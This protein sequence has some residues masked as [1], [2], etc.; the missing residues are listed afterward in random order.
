VTEPP[1][2]GLI[3][4]FGEHQRVM[5]EVSVSARQTRDGDTFTSMRCA[6]PLARSAMS[7]LCHR[8]M[9]AASL[10]SEWGSR[11]NSFIS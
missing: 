1:G 5:R 2:F 11:W 10:K 4:E 6:Y 3:R 7:I 8:A 9:L